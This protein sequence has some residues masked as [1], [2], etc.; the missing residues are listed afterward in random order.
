[1]SAL[2]DDRRHAKALAAQTLKAYVAQR[3]PSRR[4]YTRL[5]V[6]AQERAD[7]G[8]QLR[9]LLRR[10]SWRWAWHTTRVLA[11]TIRQQARTARRVRALDRAEAL[12]AE[13]GHVTYRPF[14][15]CP[16][17][18]VRCVRCDHTDHRRG[19]RPL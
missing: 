18:C 13:R 19:G 4:Q 12:C 10:R 6:R 14:P 16:P 2:T 3:R 11:I 1:M 5:E 15:S 7:L 17:S 9:R 8:A